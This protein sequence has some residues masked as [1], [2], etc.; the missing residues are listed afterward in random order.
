MIS[1]SARLAVLWGV[2]GHPFD[3]LDGVILDEA[4]FHA[5]GVHALDGLD[6]EVDGS[7]LAASL[8]DLGLVLLNILGTNIPGRL[9]TVP[10][11]KRLE[12]PL[13]DVL[14]GGAQVDLCPLQEAGSKAV[15]A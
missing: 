2:T 8:S 13:V 6:E 10:L 9:A 5:P 11:D 15:E 12:L 3:V 7:G 4:L 14:G 1:G